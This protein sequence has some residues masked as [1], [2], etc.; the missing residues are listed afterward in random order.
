MGMKNPGL[1]T[2][3]SSAVKPVKGLAVKPKNE[4]SE[5]VLFVS[6]VRHFHPELVLMSIPNGGKREPR[7][8]AQLKREGVLAGAPDLFLAEPR[9]GKSGLF[10]EMKRTV[11]GKTS[12]EQDEVIEKLKQRGYAV[13]VAKGADEA[14]REFL[15]YVYGDKPPMWC[16]R[17]LSVPGA[18]C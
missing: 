11:G 8:A 16:T 14:Y 10:I 7:V 13:V 5:Q 15:R 18:S 6:R 9:E 2:Q 12:V 1:T 17:Y 4:S 3:K